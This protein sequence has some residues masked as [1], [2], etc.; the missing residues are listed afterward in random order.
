[1][2]TPRYDEF[3]AQVETML[4]DDQKP[5]LANFREDL[6]LAGGDANDKG[7]T[8]D[9]RA[10]LQA[11]K[12]MRLTADQ[13]K[14]LKEIEDDAMKANRDAGRD[15]QARADLARQVREEVTKM[16][17]QSQQSR[18]DQLLERLDRKPS[19]R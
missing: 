7:G 11:A 19:R 3:F 12:R 9:V 17:D 15:K 2:M 18:F 10:I 5:L 13:K 6:G 16:L 4:R 14:E 8:T 1:D